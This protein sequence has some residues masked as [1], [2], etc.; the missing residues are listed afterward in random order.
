MVSHFKIPTCICWTRGGNGASHFIRFQIL[1]PSKSYRQNLAR[2]RC[3]LCVSA[4]GSPIPTPPKKSPP[5]YQ[6]EISNPQLPRSNFQAP[7]QTKIYNMTC[8]RRKYIVNWAIQKYLL[9]SGS[10]F[11][12]V[13]LFF[14]SGFFRNSNKSL[15]SLDVL[16]I[17]YAVRVPWPQNL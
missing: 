6:I 12:F 4:S 10:W 11:L 16:F 3:S 13:C 9:H 7:S 8:W 17:F 2:C 15:F 1:A 14:C 5:F